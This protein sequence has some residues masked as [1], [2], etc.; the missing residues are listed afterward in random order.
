MIAAKL[1][2][3]N[4]AEIQKNGL[5]ALKDALGVTAT[6]RFLEQFDQGGSGDYTAEKYLNAE[7]NPT[8]ISLNYLINSRLVA[9]NNTG[10]V[11]Q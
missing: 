6:I 7:H 8:V 2:V 4:Q 1:D 5:A 10:I 11:S 9:V 3:V